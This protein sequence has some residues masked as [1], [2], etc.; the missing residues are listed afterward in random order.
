MSLFQG[1][2]DPNTNDN[3]TYLELIS[4]CQTEKESGLVYFPL[5]QKKHKKHKH[6]SGSHHKKRTTRSRKIV[7]IDPDTKAELSVKEA[8][9]KSKCFIA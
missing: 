7:I 2:F 3:L 6:K 4:R 9:K 8:L 5:K 1:F